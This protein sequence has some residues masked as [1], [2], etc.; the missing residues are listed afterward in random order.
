MFQKLRTRMHA[1][2][3]ISSLLGE[4]EAIARRRGLERPSAEHLVLAAL[5]LPDGTA[6]R[7]LERLGT[8]REA[9]NAALGAQEADDLDAVG[10]RA[11]HDRI[12]AAL[13]DEKGASGL[14]RGEPSTQQLFQQASDDARRHGGQLL[15]AHVLRAA[16]ELEH[17]PTARALRRIGIDGPALRDSATA[18]IDIH[19]GS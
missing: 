8:A 18:E 4:A 11:P 10:V 6:Q 5:D 15:G 17:G 1:V 12:D 2:K 7:A 16:A 13:P 3:T 19:T 14:Y 9:F